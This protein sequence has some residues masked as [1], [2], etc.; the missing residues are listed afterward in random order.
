MLANVPAKGV[1]HGIHYYPPE[2]IFRYLSSSVG[3]TN[4]LS[5]GAILDEFSGPCVNCPSY[6]KALQKLKATPEFKNKLLYFYDANIEFNS[7]EGEE[8]LNAIV[9]TDS[10]IAW[11]KYLPTRLPPRGPPETGPSPN[12]PGLP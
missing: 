10:V 8:R 4:P 7:K 11:E 5:D 12:V 2:E 9:E 1:A 6:A 3:Y